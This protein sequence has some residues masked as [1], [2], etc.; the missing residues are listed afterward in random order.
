M[1]AER[2]MSSRADFVML[3][4]SDKDGIKFDWSFVTH[5]RRK[6]FL[7]GGLNLENI[8]QALLLNPQ[9]YALDVC[10]GVEA[11]RLK[12]YR[13]VMKFISAVRDFRTLG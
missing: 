12:D 7:S 11:N 8:Q 9:P 10:S 2:A 6:Y 3:D 5:V 13:K 4:G 1:D